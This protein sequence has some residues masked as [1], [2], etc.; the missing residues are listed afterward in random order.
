MAAYG[1]YGNT[2]VKADIA[3]PHQITDYTIDFIN[4]RQLRN[5]ASTV[6]KILNNKKLSKGIV[7]KFND[8]TTLGKILKKQT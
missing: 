2:K 6:G 1:T 3:Y 4:L 5:Q 7:G 8:D